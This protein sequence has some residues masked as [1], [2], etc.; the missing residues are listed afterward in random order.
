MGMKRCWLDLV[1]LPLSPYQTLRFK[2]AYNSF[3]GFT[4]AEL[5]IALMILGVIATFTIPKVL[6]AK[7][8]VQNNSAAKEAMATIAQAFQEARRNGRLQVTTKPSDLMQYMNYVKVDTSTVL[9]H[10]PGIASLT[11]V[12]PNGLCLLLHNGGM[13]FL[14]DSTGTGFAGASDLHAIAFYFDPNGRRDITTTADGPGKAVSLA[15]YYNGFVTTEGNLKPNTCFDGLACTEQP[16]PSKDP[17]W[18]TW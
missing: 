17:S 4:L 9:D 11:C 5:L 3:P 2:Q 7:Q 15:L 18:L 8:N 10:R 6:Q 12:S 1:V 16:D 14:R 13:L